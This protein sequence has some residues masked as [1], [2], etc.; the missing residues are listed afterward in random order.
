MA[1]AGS[2]FVVV[3]AWLKRDR[4]VAHRAPAL[5]VPRDA[6]KFAAP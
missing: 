2:A 5:D 3:M 4:S 1:A 6:Q